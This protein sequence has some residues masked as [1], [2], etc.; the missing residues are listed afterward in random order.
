MDMSQQCALTGQ[1]AN[2]TLGCIKRSVASRLREVVVPF[3]SALM[4]AL[5]QYCIQLRGPQYKKDMDLVE[6]VCRRV[7]KMIRGLEHLSYEDRL[8]ELGLFIL[9]KRKL[10]GHLIVAFQ[11]LEEAYKKTERDFLPRLVV[12]EQGVTVLN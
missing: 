7:T 5:M 12:T 2:C 6:R 8:R 10:W 3:Y 9:E 11:Y 4:R 1:K